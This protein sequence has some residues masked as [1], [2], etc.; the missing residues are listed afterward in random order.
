M[1]KFEIMKAL[2][3]LII[4]TSLQIIENVEG[5]KF[6]KEIIAI[7]IRKTKLLKYFLRFIQLEKF[8]HVSHPVRVIND[9]SK[10]PSTIIHQLKFH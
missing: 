7:S 5:F 9:F 4:T 6:N 10:E 1:V 8:V 3:I 2:L